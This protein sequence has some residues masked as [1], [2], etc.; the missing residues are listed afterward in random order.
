MKT[1]YKMRENG[2]I[3]VIDRFLLS[4]RHLQYFIYSKILLKACSSLI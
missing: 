3:S 2:Y 4:S 1:D